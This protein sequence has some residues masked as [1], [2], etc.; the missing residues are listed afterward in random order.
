[1]SRKY[2]DLSIIFITQYLSKEYWEERDDG[3]GEE[4][5]KG[6]VKGI[7]E[8]VVK[9]IEN[10]GWGIEECYAIVHDKDK[11]TDGLF[12][13]KDEKKAPHI[14]IAL[15][16][17]EGMNTGANIDSISKNVG[18]E[19]QFIERPKKGRYA[20]DNML[21]YLIHAKDS[22]KHQYHPLEVYTY[23]G[24]KYKDVY[25]KSKD[26]WARGKVI[27]EVTVTPEDY[28]YV[29]NEVLE[30]R[31][32]RDDFFDTKK[33]QLVYAEYKQ[34]LDNLFQ[35]VTE[36]K[37]KKIM[38]LIKGGDIEFTC[39]FITGKSGT[40]KT[41]FAHALAD[42]IK[43]KAKEDFDERWEIVD[44]AATN[45]VDDYN[46]EEILIL[47]DLRGTAMTTS[48]WLKLLDPHNIATA[49]AR[50]KNKRVMAR[51]I[52]ITSTLEPVQ[53][54]SITKGNKNGLIDEPIDQFLRRLQAIIKV[55]HL[56]AN[57]AECIIETS[58]VEKLP[59]GQTTTY[60]IEIE[61][62][63]GFH[64]PKRIKAERKIV[65]A[66]GFDDAQKALEYFA[67]EVMNNNDKY[68][69]RRLPF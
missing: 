66:E 18:I 68:N 13:L 58:R 67:K 65:E 4:I 61:D 15:R 47:D 26:R 16:F 50:Y 22:E 31:M 8:K 23:A 62:N 36:A 37:V 39:Y 17:K 48:D 30:G 21:A 24:M 20:W 60:E 35:V 59:E 14:H 10:A 40:G 46:G 41:R 32:T 27:K 54:F 57:L 9:R 69:I 52:I 3:L 12:A 44:A 55:I 53:F 43:Q 34:K 56:N 2:R 38:E 49:S 19:P 25:E 7:A 42:K 6:D 11:K 45:A 29:K 64:M 5:T 1:M 33:G 63:S 51:T 28:K